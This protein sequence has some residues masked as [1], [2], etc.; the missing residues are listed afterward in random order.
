MM[1]DVQEEEQTILY[2]DAASTDG[3][4]EMVKKTLPALLPGPALYLSLIHI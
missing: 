3:P 4:Y 1:S 2:W